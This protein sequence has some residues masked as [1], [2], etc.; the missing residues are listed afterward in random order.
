MQG[1]ETKGKKAEAQTTPCKHAIRNLFILEVMKHEF[2]QGDT[3]M[4]TQHNH[5]KLT[6]QKIKI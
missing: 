2:K 3:N 4:M 5:V 6:S 1:E